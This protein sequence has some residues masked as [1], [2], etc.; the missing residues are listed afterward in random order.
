MSATKRSRCSRLSTPP[1]R[2]YSNG[3]RQRRRRARSTARPARRRA[4]P[5]RRARAAARLAR[6]RA[7][8]SSNALASPPAAEQA[9]EHHAG[10]V[11]HVVE[12]RGG[13]LDAV[14]V[15]AP[16]GAEA[17]GQP[18]GP[19]GR[20]RISVSA[21]VRRTSTTRRSVARRGDEPGA[22]WPAGA[23]GAAAITRGAAPRTPARSSSTSRPACR[24]TPRGSATASSPGS[25]RGTSWIPGSASPAD[26]DDRQVRRD[27][28]RGSRSPASQRCGQRPRGSARPRSPPASR[29]TSSSGRARCACRWCR[30]RRPTAGWRVLHERHEVDDDERPRRQP[31]RRSRRARVARR[32]RRRTRTRART[33]RRAPARRRRAAVSSPTLRWMSRGTS[34][35]SAATPSALW[36]WRPRRRSPG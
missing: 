16:H 18:P 1:W 17:L 3:L 31:Q 15:A 33:G 24:P 32:G 35:G 11:E 36:R 2:R 6:A 27:P 20:P 7:R 19:R 14:R 9:H 25:S 8:S 30:D 12:E 23:T 26:H 10:A 21:V 5:R 4:P 28:R 29:S 22:C 34:S 13:V